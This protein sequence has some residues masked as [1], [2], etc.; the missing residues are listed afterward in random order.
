[1][2]KQI[3]EDQNF[4]PVH[5]AT[6]FP[7]AWDDTTLSGDS[8]RMVYPAMNDGE[9]KQMAGNGPFPWVVF[10]GDIDE[11][12]S[13]YMLLSTELVKRGNIVI[14]TQGIDEDDSDN[15]QSHL[16]LLEKIMLF[17]EEN[18]NSSTNVQGSIGQIDLKHWG[19]GGH[20]TGAAAA[21]SSLSILASILACRQYSTTKSFVWPWV[22]TLL[23]GNQVKIGIH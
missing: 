10:F 14:V 13:D 6:D 11:E 4:Q 5:T 19:I 12:A 1:M 18:N 8:V 20:G 22:P 7:V 17:M 16:V 2:R 15:L 9:S 21:Y 3:P 23:V